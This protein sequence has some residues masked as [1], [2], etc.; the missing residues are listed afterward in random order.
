M[1][2]ELWKERKQYLEEG[3]EEKQ[4]HQSNANREKMKMYGIIKK[5]RIG[6]KAQHESSK[7]TLES[8]MELSTL[9]M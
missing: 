8:L 4:T 1:A 7:E 3:E 2:A 5:L 9:L 6:H